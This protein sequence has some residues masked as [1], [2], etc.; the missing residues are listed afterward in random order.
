MIAIIPTSGALHLAKKITDKS[1][2]I[3]YPVPNKDGTFI[4]PDGEVYSRL[5]DIPKACKKVV[6]LHAGMPNPNNGLVEFEIILEAL[7]A[8]KIIIEVFFT[9]MPYSMQDKIFHDGEINASESLIKKL[10]RY[11]K[12]KKIYA[13]DAHF[14]GRDWI[15]KYSFVNIES[16]PLI[17]SAV[18]KEHGKILFVGPDEGSQRRSGVIG[19]K[20]KRK[21]SFEIEHLHDEDFFSTIKGKTIGVI[22][23][24]VETGGTLVRFHDKCMENGAK[25]MVALITHGVMESGIEKVKAKYSKLYLT[26]SIDRKEANVDISPLIIKSLQ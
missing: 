15:K 19:L 8:K 7:K 26:N 14:H 21:N 4:F 22:D 13:I 2:Q 18:E 3:L 10:L 20:K 1:I 12:V 23:D 11:Y 16:Q 17:K 24:L 6:V 25:K 9:Y 5:P